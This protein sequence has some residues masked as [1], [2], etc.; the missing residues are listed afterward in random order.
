MRV[1]LNMVVNALEAGKAGDEVRIGTEGTKANVT[2]RVWNRQPIPENVAPRI[3][4]RFF[5]TKPG[6]G[7]G[8]GTFSM[9]LLGETLLKGEVSFETSEES[10]TTFRLTLPRDPGVLEDT[11]ADP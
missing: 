4:Q 11:G 10:G 1:L 8:V 3:F 9:K 6:D 5:T 7:R 2:F